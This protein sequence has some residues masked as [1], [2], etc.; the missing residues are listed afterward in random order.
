MKKKIATF[1]AGLFSILVLAGITM[2]TQVSANEIDT[3]NFNPVRMEGPFQPVY[4]SI[5]GTEAVTGFN[6][7]IENRTGT[8]SGSRPA[9]R[10]HMWRVVGVAGE[11]RTRVQGN[12]APWTAWATS[13]TTDPAISNVTTSTATQD[14]F[15][16]QFST[17]GGGL[18][19][20]WHV[21]FTENMTI[22]GR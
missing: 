17:R 4:I 5:E 16:A 11:F 22:S 7:R 2:P 3:E 19:I 1:I 15:F 21:L 10:S 13:T 14:N 18:L 9:A 6:G 20:L 12:N 8:A